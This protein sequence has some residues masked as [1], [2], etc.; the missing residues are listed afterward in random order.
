MCR[1]RSFW[2]SLCHGDNV[3]SRFLLLLGIALGIAILYGV[4]R[5]P[6]ALPVVA[7]ANETPT[8]TTLPPPPTETPTSTTLPPPPTKTPTPTSTRT[9]CPPCPTC[10]PW[11]TYTPTAT[12][13]ATGPGICPRPGYPDYAPHGPPDFDMRQD[14]WRSLEGWTHSG[15]AAAADVL[16]WLDSKEEFERGVKY[17]L[18]TSYGLWYDHAAQNVPPLI[19]D[20]AGYVRTT[21]QGTTVEDMVTGLEE[22]LRARNLDDSFVVERIRGPSKDWIW[23]DAQQHEDI[24][25]VL[26][27][28]W[29]YDGLEWRRVGG[30]WLGI[31]C[32]DP[33]G[34]GVEFFDPFFDFAAY[35]YPGRSWGGIPPTTTHHNDA[36]NVSYDHYSFAPTGV[37]GAKWQPREYAHEDLLDVV[38]NSLGQNFGCMLEEY[39]GDYDGR[40]GVEVAADYAVVIRPGAHC[41]LLPPIETPTTTVEPSLTA[42]PMIQALEISKFRSHATIY[43]TWNF[44]YYIWVT[45]TATFTVHDIVVTDTLPSGIAP[46]SVQPG[47]GPVGNC[48]PGGSFDGVNTVT[49]TIAALA[50]GERASLCIRARTYSTMVGNYL[51]NVAEVRGTESAP[52]SAVDIAYVSA[53]PVEATATPTPTPTNTP[54]A[55]PTGTITTTPTFTP[56]PTPTATPTQEVCP[57]CPTCPPPPTPLPTP[58]SFVSGPGVCPRPGYPD[59]APHGPPDFDMRQEEWQSDGRWTHSGPLAA[60]DGLWWLDSQEEFKLGYKFGLVK[61]YGPWWDHAPYNVPLLVEDLAGYLQTGE[62]GTTVENMIAGLEEYLRAQGLENAYV[63][64]HIKGPSKDWIWLDA[65]QHEDMVLLLLGFWQYDGLRW[66]RVGG[67]WVGICCPD[68]YGIGVEFF[69]PFFD[70]AAYGYPGRSWGGIPP[71]STHHNDAANVSY[72]AYEFGKTIVPGA[73]WR[74]KNYAHERLLDVVMNSLGQNF[75][76]MLEEY[77]GAYD[78][79]LGVEVAV[80]YAVVIRPGAR[81]VQLIAT[82]TPTATTMPPET[83]TPT[84]TEAL[85]PVWTETPVP[86]QTYTPTPMNT[87]T[88]VPTP[89]LTPTL[90]PT[91]SPTPTLVV[92]GI[93][94]PLVCKNKVMGTASALNS[95]YRGLLP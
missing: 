40:L 61:P 8:S 10:P 82:A 85:T 65:Q 95:F 93:H 17:D 80:D 62:L 12:P 2:K 56:T 53:P 67:H 60:A 92:Y 77:R 59:Y 83:E 57:P 86:T 27:G 24:V 29:Q 7:Q 4:L 46:Y 34:D 38:M 64:E 51:I 30:H 76:C 15:P 79:E 50:P 32:P 31:C 73:K 37:P 13:Y 89:S 71:T 88:P 69:D 43:A 21:E 72:D 6:W 5:T 20:L 42:S 49:W 75:G 47:I 44:W 41:E 78:G 45:N 18:V 19:E 94:F 68:P 87:L 1:I 16:W 22:Y 66:W 26:L 25:L 81:C 39:R 48:Q 58:T 90:V 36:A 9:P 84:P 74:P 35:G 23:L 52:A 55:T 63:V 3:F 91:P 33:Q 14:E 54:T 70:H 11:P 28:F